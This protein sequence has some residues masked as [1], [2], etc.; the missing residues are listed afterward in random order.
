M[1]SVNA[2]E[3]AQTGVSLQLCESPVCGVRFKQGGLEISRKRFCSNEC[4]MD[5]WVLRRAIKL[6]EGLSDEELLAVMRS[7]PGGGKK[8]PA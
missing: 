4:K 6:L 7:R 5:A 1:A 3:K 2:L 8:A